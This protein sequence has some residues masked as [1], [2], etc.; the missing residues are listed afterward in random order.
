[1]LAAYLDKGRIARSQANGFD[2]PEFY[3]KSKFKEYGST[4]SDRG[5]HEAHTQVLK[6][7]FGIRSQWRTD[8]SSKQII[9]DWCRRSNVAVDLGRRI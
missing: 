2:E 6:Q 9:S 7:S 1:M 4:A 3:Y 8:V 5:D